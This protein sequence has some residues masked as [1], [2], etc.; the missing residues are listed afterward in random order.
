MRHPAI[1]ILAGALLAAS[2]RAD[3]TDERQRKE[4]IKHY[5]AGQEAL[6]SE[7]LEQAERQFREAVRLDPLLA[8]AHYGLGQV[9]MSTKRYP[10]AVRAYTQCREAFH[11]ESSLRMM[12]DK[13]ADQRLQ[14]QIQSLKD[15]LRLL[16]SGRYQRGG[17]AGQTLTSMAIRRVETEIHDLERRRHR[18]ENVAQPTPPGVSVALGSAF[19]RN[20]AFADAEREYRAA[21]AVDPDLGEAHNNLAV[22][23][24]LTG[25]LD[26]AG[27]ELKLAEKAGFQVNPGLLQDLQRRLAETGL[28][29]KP[30]D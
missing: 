10:E 8:G 29:A 16:R 13:A 4:A 1:V 3:Q 28:S 19:F 22:V 21:L 9:F 5:R 18:G 26:E 2:V 11:T 7:D 24:M 25:R 14:D 20:G 15:Y 6:L 23:Y 30:R 27:D 12:N 17:Q